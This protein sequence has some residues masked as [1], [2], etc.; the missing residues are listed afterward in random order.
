MRS[1]S[2][3]SS[4]DSEEGDLCGRL[5]PQP[6]SL[7]LFRTTIR[8]VMA[9]HVKMFGLFV[10]NHLVIRSVKS[11]LNER[12][13]TTDLRLWDDVARAVERLDDTLIGYIAGEL[14][15]AFAT[16]TLQAAETVVLQQESRASRRD[17]SE[18]V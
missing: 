9:A 13:L 17:L 6:S 18:D 3:I 16:A 1:A 5:H 12:R 14:K 7:S 8:N 15:I 11:Y 2:T 4:Q 10:R